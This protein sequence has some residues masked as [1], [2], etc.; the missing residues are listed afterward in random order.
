MSEFY[1]QKASLN[2]IENIFWGQELE[3]TPGLNLICGENGTGKTRALI[4]LKSQPGLNGN[5][6]GGKVPFTNPNDITGRILAISPKRNSDKVAVQN[7]ISR[8]RNENKKL[9]QLAAELIGTQLNDNGFTSYKSFGELFGYI[10]ENQS[11][12]GKEGREKIVKDTCKDFNKVLLN[13]FDNEYKFEAEWNA[14]NGSPDLYI[15]KRG[16]RLG[17]GDISTGEQEILSL[18]FN[19]YTFRDHCDIY[20]IDEPE[21]HLNWSLEKK[22]FVFLRWFANTYEKQ[23]IAVTHSRIV[24]DN[25]FLNDVQFFMWKRNKVV[26]TKKI[27]SKIQ[28]LI[29]GELSMYTKAT[30]IDRPLIY[31]EDKFSYNVI[32]N[33][34]NKYSKKNVDIQEANGKSNVQKLFKYQHDYAKNNNVFGITDGDNEGSELSRDKSFIKLSKYCLENYFLDFD[35]IDKFNSQDSGYTKELLKNYFKNLPEDKSTVFIKKLADKAGIEDIIGV[36][37]YY[38]G[39]TILKYLLK[40]KSEEFAKFFIETKTQE[41]LELI[42]DKKLIDVIKGFK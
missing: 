23:V 34:L 32:L 38:D 14:V 22:L 3:F 30:K 1:I 11:L 41:E 12:L 5:I 37:D 15:N 10:V 35:L 27:P 28:K 33:L 36:L 26:V 9:E 25:D 8:I 31:V 24:F 29:A 18:I 21:T 39:S 6:F 4:S 42:F 40:S 7:F 17:L 20:L 16:S 2:L 19:I 13:I